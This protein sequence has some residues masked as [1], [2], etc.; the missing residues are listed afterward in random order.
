MNLRKEWVDIGSEIEKSIEIVI[1][2]AKKKNP[3]AYFHNLLVS[4]LQIFC[5]RTRIR[6][7]ILNL[8]SNAVRYT[9]D[10]PGICSSDNY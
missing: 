9:L 2:L 7:V 10:R 8:L 1:P 5:D 6:Q 3:C 4:C